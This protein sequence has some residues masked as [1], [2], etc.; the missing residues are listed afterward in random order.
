VIRRALC[1]ATIDEGK[2]QVFMANTKSLSKDERKKLR[3]AS[4]KKRKAEKP[5]QARD[6]PRGSKKGKVK[7]LVRGQSKR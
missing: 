3:R 5:L 1:M 2:S 4:R 7:K 6:Y